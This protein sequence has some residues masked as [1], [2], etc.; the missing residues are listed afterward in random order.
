MISDVAT[1]QLISYRQKSA[2]RKKRRDKDTFLKQQAE[3]AN[4]NRKR[5]ELI[6]KTAEA[7]ELGHDDRQSELDEN[8]DLGIAEG[9]FGQEAEAPTS[10]K[11]LSARASLPELLPAEYLEDDDIP[12]AEGSKVEL[13][14]RKSKKTKFTDLIEK[15]P[16]DRRKGSTTY[17]VLN[18]GDTLLLAPKASHRA[19]SIKDSWMQGRPVKGGETSRKPFSQGFFVKKR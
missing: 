2:I 5:A 1:A 3:S 6:G 19:R 9:K 14:S 10:V 7:A 18:P 8:S 11:L 17:R 16:K 13:I 15:K 4:K 12:T